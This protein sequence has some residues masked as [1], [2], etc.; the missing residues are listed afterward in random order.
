VI[1]EP[2][3]AFFDFA[4]NEEEFDLPSTIDLILSEVEPGDWWDHHPCQY[5]P[6]RL[7]SR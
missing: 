3:R 6:A 1:S 5:S 2:H 4:Q 7:T